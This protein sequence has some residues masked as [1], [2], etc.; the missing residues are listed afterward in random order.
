MGFMRTIRTLLLALVALGTAPAPAF[1]Q[2]APELRLTP[3]VQHFLAFIE[4]SERGVTV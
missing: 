2:P 4:A 3:E 1:A